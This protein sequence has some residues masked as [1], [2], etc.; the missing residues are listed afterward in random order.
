MMFMDQKIPTYR[1]EDNTTIKSNIEVYHK[2]FKKIHVRNK[3]IKS[4]AWDIFQKCKNERMNTPFA[5][6]DIKK[7]LL[8]LWPPRGG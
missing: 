1:N 3:R 7:S 8:L 2:Q 5:A 4:M 6:N